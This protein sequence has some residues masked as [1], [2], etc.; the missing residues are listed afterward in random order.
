[1]KKP[2][3]IHPIIKQSLINGA[4]GYIFGSVLGSLAGDNKNNSTSEILKNMNSTGIK[5]GMIGVTYTVTEYGIEKARNKKCQWNSAIAGS[6]AAAT[7][8]SKKGYKAMSIGALAFGMYTGFL[9]L[10]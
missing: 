2:Y 3:T 5:F 9:S 6:V 7:V 1:M 10:L 4:K 8:N